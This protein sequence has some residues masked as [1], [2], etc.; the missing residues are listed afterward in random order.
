MSSETTLAGTS[1]VF[2]LVAGWFLYVGMSLEVTVTT[3]EGT[4][5]NLQL[6]HMQATNIAI[7][8]GAAI[9][10]AILA[11]GSAVVAAIRRAYELSDPSRVSE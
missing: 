10:S 5:A 7:A 9:V 8:I 1:F 3:A 2:A 4:V 11:V 6:M